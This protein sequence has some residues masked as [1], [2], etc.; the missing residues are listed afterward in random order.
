MKTILIR[1][2]ANESHGYGHLS[3]CITIA[4]G[5]KGRN[6]NHKITFIG[7]YSPT[8]I[9]LIEKRN[10]S[11]VMFQEH[12]ANDALNLAHAL[13]NYEY[14]ILDSY[15]I[16]QNYVDQ[17]SNQAYK[18]C[19]VADDSTAINLASVDLV[20]NYAINGQKFDY[21]SKSQALGLMYFPVKPE[22]KSVRQRNLLKN[23]RDI[24]HILLMIG[25]HD[26]YAVGVKLLQILDNLVSDRKITYISSATSLDMLSIKNNKLKLLPF[27]ENIED[28]YSVVDLTIT[29]GGLSKYESNYCNI[30]NASVPQNIN[31]YVDSTYFEAEGLT[32]IVG[33]AYDFSEVVARKNI[34]KLLAAPPN[35]PSNLFCTNS[36]DHLIDKIFQ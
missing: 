1:C 25:G 18:F 29:G 8:A 35:S 3:R 32:S 11:Y 12:T 30:R 6:T 24:N 36:L 33:V 10:F 31:E 28:I 9:T 22:L 13:K 4:R 26:V 20:I 21:K 14:L 2:D 23:E 5:I 19:I 27:Y 7:D 15:D 16:T 17:L 34:A